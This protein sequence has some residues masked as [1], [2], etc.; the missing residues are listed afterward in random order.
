MLLKLQPHE[1][2]E[3]LEPGDHEGQA[4]NGDSQRQQV[5][6]EKP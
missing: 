1:T 2:V 6:G 5:H 3:R 4:G